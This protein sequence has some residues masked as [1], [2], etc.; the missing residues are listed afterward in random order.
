[1]RKFPPVTF[2]LCIAAVGCVRGASREAASCLQVDAPVHLSG[3][4]AD[5]QVY[6]PPGYGEDTTKD[7]KWH[8]PVLLLTKPFD[9]C[10]DAGP[11]SAGQIR[12]PIRRVEL[13]F[14]KSPTDSL[15]Q[16]GRRIVVHGRLQR[17]S[18]IS[19]LTDPVLT[20]DSLVQANGGG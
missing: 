19:Q 14:S 10:P 4:A 6:G 2:L 16:M 1:M 17:R 15:P 12:S 5:T 3:I 11:D 9:L 7:A 20:V 8:I 18:T 13:D